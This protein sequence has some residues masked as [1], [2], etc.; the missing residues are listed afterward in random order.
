VA[1]LRARGVTGA[2]A[3]PFKP[4]RVLFVSDLPRTRNLKVMRRVIR[5]VLTG[6]SPGDLAALV[7]PETVEELRRLKN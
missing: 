4:Q 5:A 7:N 1:G 6:A 3:A 2:R